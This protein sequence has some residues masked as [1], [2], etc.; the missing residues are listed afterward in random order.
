MRTKIILAL[1][2]FGLATSLSAGTAL[3]C[4]N[5]SN[6]KPSWLE[7][8]ANQTNDWL[9]DNYQQL[10]A[11]RNGSEEHVKSLKQTQDAWIKL[12]ESQ[13]KLSVKNKEGNIT[14]ARLK[15]EIALTHKRAGELEKLAYS[16]TFF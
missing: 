15:C 9:N 8:C 12:R 13:C 14:L 4:T 7:A 1:T 2:S 5:T 3:N 10:L 16:S 6:M 11:K